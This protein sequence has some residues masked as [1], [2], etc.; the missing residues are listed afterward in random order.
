MEVMANWRLQPLFA[1]KTD[2]DKGR[3]VR[4]KPGLDDL[5]K[6]RKCFDPASP[7]HSLV[8]TAAKPYHFMTTDTS[9]VTEVLKVTCSRER[10]NV[11]PF[12]LV[13]VETK[14]DVKLRNPTPVNLHRI[15]SDAF[16]SKGCDQ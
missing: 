2:P 13:W 12:C 16:W 15:G 1:S 4:P 11:S 9:V 10:V 7:V 5:D 14:T 8:P 6:R 3:W